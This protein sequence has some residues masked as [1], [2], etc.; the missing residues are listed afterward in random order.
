MTRQTVKITTARAK[1]IVSKTFPEYK[2]RKFIV[3]F[4]DTVS[5][6][7][8]NWSGG[9]RNFYEAVRSDGHH[10]R[11][12]SFSP[13]NNPAEGRKIALTPDILI[14]ERAYFCGKDCG[15]TIYAHPCHL[16]KWIEGG[17]V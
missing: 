3:E 15:I 10:E 13:W 2:G 5:F 9:T 12:P 1:P 14:V 17:V 8:T 11:L 4:T 6:Y 7:D 16:P